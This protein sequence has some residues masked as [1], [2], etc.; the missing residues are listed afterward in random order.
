MFLITGPRSSYASFCS[1]VGMA[2]FNDFMK[3]P[4]RVCGISISYI[5]TKSLSE[6]IWVQSQIYNRLSIATMDT[7]SHHGRCPLSILVT[8]RNVII[9]TRDVGNVILIEDVYF[10]DSR[11]L[12]CS[13]TL[14]IKNSI[15][16]SSQHENRDCYKLFTSI[17]DFNF[18]LGY[19]HLLLKFKIH[20]CELIYTQHNSVHR[21][22]PWK[23]WVFL[24]DFFPT[25]CHLRKNSVHGIIRMLI[26][27]KN[28][29]FR[30]IQAL[31]A[32]FAYFAIGDEITELW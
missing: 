19:Y 17:N 27:I 18:D 4:P 15:L 5:D 25:P 9:I 24:M 3:N 28:N 14:S 1:F 30:N 31:I 20:L 21:S 2:H 7:C 23:D 22:G 8:I 32:I 12:K 26:I 16:H 11:F 29:N 13:K 6:D 10:K